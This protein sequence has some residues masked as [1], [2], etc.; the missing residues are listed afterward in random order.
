MKV[1]FSILPLVYAHCNDAWGWQEIDMCPSP[2]LTFDSYEEPAA[3]RQGPA[4]ARRA[5]WFISR[6]SP[7]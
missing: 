4:A 7:K 2:Q 3:R 5:R 1:R 6:C